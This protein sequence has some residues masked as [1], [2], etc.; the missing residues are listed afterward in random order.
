MSEHEIEMILS[1]LD[2][3]EHGL[4]AICVNQKWIKEGVVANSKVLA[5]LSE[6]GLARCKQHDK[7]IASMKHALRTRNPDAPQDQESG[8]EVETP[9]GW[10]GHAHGIWGSITAV[11]FLVIVWLLFRSSNTATVNAD[12]A[13]IDRDDIAR[14]VQH[15]MRGLQK[16]SAENKEQVA[17]VKEQTE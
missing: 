17:I 15:Q 13:K 4:V 8:F 1:R 11:L 5:T 14:I 9:S 3:P 2:D 16:D 10:K 6:E 7:D 12:N